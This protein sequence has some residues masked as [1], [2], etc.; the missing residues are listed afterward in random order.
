MHG[1]LRFGQR[2][3][4]TSAILTPLASR[5]QM[6]ESLKYLVKEGLQKK[7]KKYGKNG[8]EDCDQP[9]RWMSRVNDPHRGP[10]LIISR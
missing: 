4:R 1:D 9:E 6:Q 7:K 8:V 5:D 10:I 3:R 2:G